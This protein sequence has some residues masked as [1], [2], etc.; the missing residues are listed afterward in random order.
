MYTIAFSSFL[1]SVKRERHKRET[2]GKG[3][4]TR[5]FVLCHSGFLSVCVTL[6]RTS[7]VEHFVHDGIAIS[8]QRLL[9]GNFLDARLALGRRRR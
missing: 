7:E 4:R 5:D 2:C 9:D 1:A 3:R 8:F 6:I